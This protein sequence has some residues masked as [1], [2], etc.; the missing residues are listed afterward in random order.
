[1]DKEGIRMISKKKKKNMYVDNKQFLAD[2]IVWKQKSHLA[3]AKGLEAPRL[4]EYIGKC[5]FLIVENYARKPRFMNYSF[6]EEMKSDAIENCLKYFD[7]FDEIKY[8]NP[9][10]YF[11]QITHYAFHRRIN[12]EEKKRYLVY[13][14]FQESLSGIDHNLL[15]DSDD[16]LVA[17]PQMYENINEFIRNFEAKEAVKKEKRKKAKEGL[18]KYMEKDNENN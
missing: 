8:S 17:S 9:F 6:V 18:E 10:A 11:T 1:V 7:N 12:E 3:K 14:S 13:K 16:N 4:S 2:I 5:I 15:V